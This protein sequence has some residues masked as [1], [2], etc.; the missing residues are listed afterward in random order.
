MPAWLSRALV[1]VCLTSAASVPN[2][3][4][5]RMDL[6]VLPS[7]LL[8]F[9]YACYPAKLIFHDQ[10]AKT[11]DCAN[12]IWALPNHQMPGDFHIGG[13]QSQDVFSLPLTSSHGSCAVNIR[14]KFGRN[15]YS[16]WPESALAATRIVF[17]C[18]VGDTRQGQ[19]GGQ[20]EIGENKFLI[21]TVGQP[22]SGPLQTS[23]NDTRT[24]TAKRGLQQHELSISSS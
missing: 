17:N 4:S 19:T 7:A 14:L 13:A 11:L 22:I 16:S 10:R 20:A 15:D 9:T 21:V 18:A 24:A 3:Q 23:D 8:G 5:S 1:L 12:A 6:T 2:R